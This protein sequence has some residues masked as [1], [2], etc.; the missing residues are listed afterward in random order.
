MKLWQ[1]KVKSVEDFTF[2]SPVDTALENKA[3]AFES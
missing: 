2:T 1:K 3:L